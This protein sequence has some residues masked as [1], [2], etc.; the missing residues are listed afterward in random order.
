MRA[1]HLQVLP[2]S[3]RW[4]GGQWLAGLVLLQGG[5]AGD[6]QARGLQPQAI[7]VPERLSHPSCWS[8]SP[9]SGSLESCAHT[10]GSQQ[11]LARDTGAF[12]APAAYGLC[13]RQ[14][15]LAARPGDP[16]RSGCRVGPHRRGFGVALQKRPAGSVVIR[17]RA[18][19]SKAA[20][21]LLLC[22]WLK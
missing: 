14:P 19:A 16:P 2:A 20:S 6:E 12:Q 9:A 7:H 13:C 10:Q 1:K 22:A 17:H 21:T 11:Q 8:P 3:R 18:Q 5:D 4:R 15:L